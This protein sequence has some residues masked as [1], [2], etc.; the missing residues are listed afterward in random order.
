MSREQPASSF[1]AANA[2]LLSD[3]PQARTD[4]PGGPSF[5]LTGFVRT[6][7][8]ASGQQI[9]QRDLTDEEYAAELRAA[10]TDPGFAQWVL[11]TDASIRAG[12]VKTG[13]TVLADLVGFPLIPLSQT[14]KKVL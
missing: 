9:S 2:V 10:G 1:A 5:T 7:T 12:E 3:S 4:E 14:V 6:V 11:Q 8:E 13:S